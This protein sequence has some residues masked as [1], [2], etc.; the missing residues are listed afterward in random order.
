MSTFVWCLI[1]IGI[2]GYITVSG[3]S[4]DIKQ[5]KFEIDC[6]KAR[7]QFLL[8]ENRLLKEKVDYLTRNNSPI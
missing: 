5:L 2:T 6:L 7:E 3:A 1:W 8:E 4:R